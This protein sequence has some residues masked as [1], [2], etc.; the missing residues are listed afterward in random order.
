MHAKLA[1]HCLSTA[2][3]YVCCP[4]AAAID[5]GLPMTEAFRVADDILHS[6]VRGISDI[7]TVP[8][9]VNVDFAD[10]R[11]IMCGAGSSLMAQGV[12]S[13][14]DRARQAALAATSS[15]LLEVGIEQAT[16]IVWNIT[17]PADMTLYEVRDSSRSAAKQL[18]ACSHC[19]G[20]AH[21]A[22][23]LLSSDCTQHC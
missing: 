15:P 21:Q 17:G 2:L 19:M 22:A 8:G 12:A 5:P 4:V 11:A 1:M 13:G 3:R 7:I 10:V 16:G 20:A 23:I 6:G 18:G 14:K 9:L